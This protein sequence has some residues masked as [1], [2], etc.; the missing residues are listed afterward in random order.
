[1]GIVII[2]EE[3]EQVGVYLVQYQYLVDLFLQVEDIEEDVIVA[4][5]A[6]GGHKGS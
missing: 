6:H 4:V 1:M 3:E 2:K 5:H